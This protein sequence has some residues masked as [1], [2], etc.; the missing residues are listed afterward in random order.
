LTASL[1]L[2]HTFLRFH[3]I[4][5][6]RIQS[7]QS[8]RLA[9]ILFSALLLLSLRVQA[10]PQARQP[11][12]SQFK[13]LSEQAAKASSENRLDEAAALYAKALA[14]RPRWTDGWWSLATIEYD[15][16]H[17]AK[18]AHAF[19]KV[20]ALDS[21]NGTAH[22]MLGLCQ[23][24]LH[25]DDAALKNLLA[26]ENIGVIK[27]QQ[28][29]IVA[30]YHMGVLELRFGKYGAAKETFGQLARDHIRSKELTT[31]MGLAALLIKSP[32][33]PAESTP[34][35]SVVE[36]VGE[37]ELFLTAN[38]FDQAKQKYIQLI[39]EFPD[40]PNL[41]F[42]FGR[43]LLETH[44][45]DQAIQQFEVELQRD[46]K[47]VDS[48][49]EIAV[50]RQLVD[51]Q[52]GLKYAED[53]AK[54]APSLPFAHYILG[55]LRLD[56]GDANGAIPQ[57]EIAC[58]AFPTEAGVYFALGRAYSKVGRKEDAGKAR[59]EFARLNAQ[60]AKQPVGPTIYG[61]Q[62]KSLDKELPH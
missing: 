26:A 53:A 35:A 7:T 19:E 49:L 39:G 4:F 56:T 36:G 21:K 20:I 57:L 3:I 61:E 43:V 27:D 30:L 55:M 6:V 40:Y 14:L 12:A 42:A 45:N 25:Q 11:G 22:A 50:A 44:E 59:A 17:Y 33:A 46:P 23:F 60:A 47:H 13:S 16:D 62:V 1:F 28:L 10:D 52:A 37:A 41:H 58:K 31:G 38:D 18:A 29:R 51:P 34:A 5:P 54:L 2:H 15:R 48:M 32:D 24:E 8:V 9:G